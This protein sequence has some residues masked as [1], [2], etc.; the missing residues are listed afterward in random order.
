MSSQWHRKRSKG[1][2]KAS[3]SSTAWSDWSWNAERKEWASFRSD[4]RGKTEWK[5][6]LGQSTSGAPA[7]I[8]I[9]VNTL[10]LITVSEETSQYPYYSNYAT[11]GNDIDVASEAATTPASKANPSPS[12]V[13]YLKTSSPHTQRSEFDTRK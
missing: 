3:S 7:S 2:F 11:D 10:P 6:E 4:S 1:S 9:P 12:I 13:Y 5:F 8:C